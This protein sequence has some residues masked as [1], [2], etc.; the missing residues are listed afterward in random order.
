MSKQTLEVLEAAIEAHT[1]AGLE[2]AALKG[3]SLDSAVVTNW[4][5]AVS[6]SPSRTT[7]R[8]TSVEATS[9]AGSVRTR[10][11][12]CTRAVDG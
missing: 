12:R 5:V 11:P 2:E 9:T 6:S 3:R 4:I 8:P 10:M 7:A 1:K